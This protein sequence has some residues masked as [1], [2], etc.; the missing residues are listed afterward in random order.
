MAD[1]GQ[2]LHRGVAALA[3]G[4]V[5]SGDHQYAFGRAAF[6]QMVGQ[7][8]QR[9]TRGAAQLYGICIVGL[10]AEMFGKHRAQHQMRKRGGVTAEQTVYVFALQPGVVQSQRGRVGHQVQRRFARQF[11]EGREAAAAQITHAAS[12]LAGP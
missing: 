11:A 5:F 6:H 1:L 2:H 12:V 9:K 7:H 10:Q 3:G 8:D 4:A